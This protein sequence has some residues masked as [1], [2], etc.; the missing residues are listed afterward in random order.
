MNLAAIFAAAEYKTLLIGGDLRKPKLHTDFKID[1]NKGLSSYLLGK[2][3]ISEIIQNSHIENLHI[4]ASGPIPSKP[5]ELIE[6]SKMNDI[7]C[8]LKQNM[9]I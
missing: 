4:I 1:R 2:H 7:I 6:S 9:T 3:K 5:A 8:K